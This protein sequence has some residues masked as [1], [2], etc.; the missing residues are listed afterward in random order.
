MRESQRVVT[1]R[2]P[3][4]LALEAVL[5]I[6]NIAADAV[7]TELLWP[8]SR[9]LGEAE[10]AHSLVVER[11]WLGQVQDVEFDRVP[12]AG[13]ADSEEEPLRMTVCIDVVLEHQVVLVVADFHRCE[14]VSSFESRF[15]N[16]CL[17]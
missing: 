6:A 14:Q 15:K 2:K 16:Q 3:I 7:P 11:V 1:T 4:A 17:I 5:M 8:I 9:V 12:I 13:V 10:Y